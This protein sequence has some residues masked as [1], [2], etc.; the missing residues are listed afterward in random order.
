MYLSLLTS[1][2]FLIVENPNTWVLLLSL[3]L[4]FTFLQTLRSFFPVNNVLNNF[5]L[6]LQWGISFIIQIIDGTFIPQIY[7]FIIL[8]EIAYTFPLKISIPSA[9]FCFFGFAS[10]IYIH[11][12]QPPLEEISYVL[13]RSIEYALFFGISYMTKKVTT[14]QQLLEDA[15][16]KLKQSYLQAEEKILIDERIRLS[17]EIHDTIGHT[18]TTSFI[19]IET[20]KK[21]ISAHKY[22]EAVNKLEQVK[23]HLKTSIEQVRKS[24][25]TLHNQHSFIDFKD[26]LQEL[27]KETSKHANVVIHAHITKL[28]KMKP[29]QEL[30]LY[31]AL[32]EGLTNGIRHGKSSEFHFWLE[33]REEKVHFVL[34][35]N[36]TMP[37]NWKNGFG[38]RSMEERVMLLDGHMNVSRTVE[39]GCRLSFTMPLHK[40]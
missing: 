2:W 1:I 6:P 38:L 18:L 23:Q 3:A 36:G 14:Q 7:F 39:G 20:G 9:F 17:R 26:S 15:Y 27:I 35:D 37:I 8:V 11:Y 28:P 16:E 10:G 32:Q 12:E 19:G 30:T 22:T 25:K 34:Q 21:L 33:H 13:P 5:L 29:Q 40:K 4:L 31:R 24:V